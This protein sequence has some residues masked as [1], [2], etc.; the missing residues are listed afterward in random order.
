MGNTI[1]KQMTKILDMNNETNENC[2]IHTCTTTIRTAFT[3]HDTPSSG[4]TGCNPSVEI[5]ITAWKSILN[6]L[7]Q[8]LR[9]VSGAW[10]VGPRSVLGVGGREGEGGVSFPR[11]FPVDGGGVS[12]GG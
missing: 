8:A 2:L 9:R 5:H 6:T 11:Y 4:T 7:R 12:G 3:V 10:N 1:T